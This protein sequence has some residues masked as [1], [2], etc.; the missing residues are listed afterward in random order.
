MR[1][2]YLSACD[3]VRGHDVP[4]DEALHITGAFHTAGFQHVIGTLWPAHD[5]EAVEIVTSFYAK[6][7]GGSRPATGPADASGATRALH[8]AVR[9]RR[10]ENSATPTLWGR[11]SMTE[12][13][14]RSR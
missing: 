5:E 12:H 13:D 11:T 10:A 7:T 8:N 1:S 4:T 6:V 3:T 14:L 9:A 2:W